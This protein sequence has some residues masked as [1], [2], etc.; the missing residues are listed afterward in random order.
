MRESRIFFFFAW[1]GRCLLSFWWW[2]FS[3]WWTSTLRLT[4]KY[5]Y[6]KMIPTVAWL[7]QWIDFFPFFF[8]YKQRRFFTKSRS[9]RW[10]TMRRQRTFFSGIIH[11][12]SFVGELNIIIEYRVLRLRYAMGNVAWTL[13]LW[14]EIEKGINLLLVKIVETWWHTIFMTVR[15]MAW[16]MGETKIDKSFFFYSLSVLTQGNG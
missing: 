10:Q 12:L 11:S 8:G 13:F 2:I 5:M 14:T 15:R 4:H 9:S 7:K 3:V 16:L 6:I 1:K